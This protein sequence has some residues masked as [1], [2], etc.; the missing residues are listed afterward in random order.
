MPRPGSWTFNMNTTFWRAID[1]MKPF[2]D[3]L[4]G[5]EEWKWDDYGKAPDGSPPALAGNVQ[6][7]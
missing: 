1:N 4:R 2:M 3:N 5:S 6:A 7:E